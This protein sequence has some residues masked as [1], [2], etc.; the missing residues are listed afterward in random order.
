MPLRNIEIVIPVIQWP[1]GDA[2]KKKSGGSMYGAEGVLDPRRDH[3]LK[4]SERFYGQLYER[5]LKFSNYRTE[6]FKRKVYEKP[7]DLRRKRNK[8][9][10]VCITDHS[11][12]PIVSPPPDRTHILL[13]LYVVAFTTPFST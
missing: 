2:L 10:Q 1:A 5:E 12:S 9:R 8:L 7:W 3:P 11:S 13:L 4:E 6:M